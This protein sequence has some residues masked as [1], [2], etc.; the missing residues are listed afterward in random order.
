M[1]DTD[2]T[3]A[4]L[5][6]GVDRVI[7]GVIRVGGLFDIADQ[8]LKDFRRFNISTARMR[9]DIDARR[10]HPNVVTDLVYKLCELVD[11]QRGAVLASAGFVCLGVPLGTGSVGEKK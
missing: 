3:N 7:V 11:L 6:R 10:V 4:T 2:K 1:V 8:P 5:D 9:N